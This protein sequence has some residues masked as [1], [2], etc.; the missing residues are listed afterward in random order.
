MEPLLET[1]DVDIEDTSEL[2]FKV[3]VEG[4]DQSPAKI[5]LVCESGDLAYMFNGRPGPDGLVQFVLPAM[6]DKLKEGLYQSRVEVLIENRY[7]APVQ[8]QLNFKRAVRVVAEAVTL[9]QRKPEPAVIV[10]AAPIV[11]PE[12]KVPVQPPKQL[13]KRDEQKPTLK[14]RFVT[15]KND[16]APPRDLDDDA[17]I[18]AASAFVKERRK[19]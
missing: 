2:L 16:V 19:K 13:Q 4:A 9:V 8:F 14:E 18:E 3:T 12:V 1:L 17:I 5:R 7:F 15:K 11:K 10:T 6:K